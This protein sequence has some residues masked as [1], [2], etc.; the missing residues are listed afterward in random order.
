MLYM[1]KLGPDVITEE[2]NIDED[3]PAGDTDGAAETCV[4]VQCQRQIKG[5]TLLTSEH[6]SDSDSVRTLLLNPD[7]MLGPCEKL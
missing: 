4:S 3:D 5:G 7:C 1:A 2:I 6:A